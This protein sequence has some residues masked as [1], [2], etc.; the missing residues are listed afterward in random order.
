MKFRTLTD[1]ADLEQ[2]ADLQVAVWELEAIEIIPLHI[3]LPTI[4]NG[5]VI[6][7]AYDNN[8]QLVGFN[9]AHPF[10]RGQEWGLWSHITGVH[11][12]YQRQGFGFGLKQAQRQWAQK[13]GYTVIRWTFDPLQRGNAKFNLHR[14]GVTV[15]AYHVNYYGEMRDGINVGLPSDR[16]EA[17]WRL[18]DERVKMLAK[19]AAETEESTAQPFHS[20]LLQMDE[21]GQPVVDTTPFSLPEQP[22]LVEIPYDLVQ[23]KRDSLQAARIW[24]LALRR[25]LAN[26]FSRGYAAVD[27]VVE[28]ERCWYVLRALSI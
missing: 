25:V 14:L 5:G 13:N 18:D 12:D 28:K 15:S 10:R 1:P 27:F 16:V 17:T 11:P 7:G 4:H 23:L 6:I 9:F 8:A 21:N 19:G 26:A 24:Q 3:F 20:Y 22:C 2:L